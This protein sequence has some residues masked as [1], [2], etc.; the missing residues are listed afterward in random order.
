MIARAYDKPLASA[1][2]IALWKKL[3]EGSS[4][5]DV[6]DGKTTNGYIYDLSGRRVEKPVKGLYIID[7]RKVFVK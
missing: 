1:E 6:R 5:A 2:V 4:I 7:G 3:N